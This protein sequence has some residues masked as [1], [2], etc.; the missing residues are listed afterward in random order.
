MLPTT[1]IN[2]DNCES[3]VKID[4]IKWDI[5]EVLFQEWTILNYFRFMQS[6]QQRNVKVV[7]GRS[8][9]YNI[10]IIQLLKFFV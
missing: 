1:R 6:N 3:F 10:S 4:N 9:N 8:W 2:T 5:A 7:K